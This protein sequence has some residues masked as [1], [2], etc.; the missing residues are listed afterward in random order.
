M[1]KQDGA[2]HFTDSWGNDKRVIGVCTNVLLLC[3]ALVGVGW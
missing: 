1:K 3:V 2:V